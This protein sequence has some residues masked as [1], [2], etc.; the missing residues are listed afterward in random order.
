MSEP[1]PVISTDPAP[2]LDAAYWSAIAAATAIRTGHVSSREYLEHLLDRVERLNPPLNTVVTL[3]AERARHEA[4]AADQ[5]LAEGRSL[6]PL[7]GVA[8]TIKDSFQT[9][10]MRTTSGA[11]ELSGHVPEVDALPV[12]R[13]RAAGAVVF[14]KTNLPIYAGDTQSYNEVFG[15]TNNPWN[16]ER[17]PGGSSGGSAAALAAGL[18]PFEL[19]SDIG[20][21]IRGPASTCG[22]FGHKP[23]YGIVP[24]LGQIPGP[25]GTLTQADIAVAGPMARTVEDLEL[26]LD[27]LAGPDEW[28]A[29]GYRLDLPPPRHEDISDYRVAVWFDEDSCPI[30]DRVRERLEAAAETLEATGA[31]VDRAARP[32]F[33]FDYATRVFGQLLGAAMCGGFSHQEIEELAVRGLREEEEGALAA[34]WAS[35]RHRAWLSA[36]ERRLQMRRKWREFFKEWDAVLLPSL[37][38]TAIPHDHSEP[39]GARRITVNG[40]ERAYGEQ[41]LWVGLTGVAYLP[42]TVIPA[43][44]AA[45]GL[46]VGLQIAGPF[47]EDR[48]TLDLA[49]RLS[50]RIGGFERP[51]GY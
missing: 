40:E 28:H 12:A 30:D 22:V 19:G 25:P 17:T 33:T 7:H 1:S 21:S 18:T 50:D 45:D 37:P 41:T 35:Q 24:A 11:P 39:M 26:G 51:P 8:I 27:I 13:L 49:R 32:D 34:R 46:P 36:N 48:T 2:A 20:G 5:A 9:I 6:G 31:T 4:D 10:G 3:D 14:G 44:A 15:Q 42:A 29:P 43:G 38:T 23:S 47:L 16:L